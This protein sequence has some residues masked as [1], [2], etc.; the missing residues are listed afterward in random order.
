MRKVKMGDPVIVAQS[1]TEPILFGGYQDPFIRCNGQGELYVR[2]N[3]RRDCHETFGTETSNPVY[4]S[5]DAGKTWEFLPNPLYSWITARKSLPNGDYLELREHSIVT[6]LPELPPLPEGRD[7]CITIASSSSV[8]LVDELLPVLGDRVA[9]EF[10]AYR[11]LAGT[12]EIV[13]ETCR[14]NWKNMPLR[15]FN[16]RKP[17]L[18]RIFGNTYR[19]DKNGVLWMPVNGPYIDDS[20]KL[21]SG[22]DCM[23]MLRSDDMGHTWDYVSSVVYKEE[24]NHPDAVDVEGFSETTLEI[25]DDGSLFCIMRSGSLHPFKMGKENHPIPKLYAVK[26]SDGGKTWTKPVP[27]YD[28]GVFPVSV[29]LDCGSIIM[30]S[31]RPGVYIRT[32]DDHAAENWNDVIPILAVPDEDVYKA[33]YEYSCSNTGVC[34]YDSNTAFLVYSNFRLNDPSGKRAKSILVQK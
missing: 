18:S 12:E 24:Y 1:T 4:K 19:V 11:V 30:S 32:C 7:N 6:D 34:G 23:H 20:G 13:E 29:K 5:T 2:F 15:Y 33:Y 14:I 26:S 9:K 21:G 16:N 22:Y 8:Y 28:Y 10:K 3:T 25:L 31:G 17:F 27:F